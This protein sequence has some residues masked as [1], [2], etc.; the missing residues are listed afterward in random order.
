MRHELPDP[1]QVGGLWC[2]EVLDLLEPYLAGD[3]DAERRDAIEAHLRGCDHCA[4]FGG[5]YREVVA[6][7]RR[8]L[9][10]VPSL[11]AERAE[12]LARRLQR[13]LDAS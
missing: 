13:A 4:A 9:G 3:L 12:R 2:H 11:D 6:A 7:L 1:R 10:A 8:T 5:A